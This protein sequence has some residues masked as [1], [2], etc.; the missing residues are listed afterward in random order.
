MTNEQIAFVAKRLSTAQK[1]LLADLPESIEDAMRFWNA[2][3]RLPS[4]RALARFGL[5]GMSGNIS[6]KGLAVRK[7]LE[8]QNG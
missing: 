3:K 4:Y 2:D 6:P 1:R 8:D 5:T 7:I